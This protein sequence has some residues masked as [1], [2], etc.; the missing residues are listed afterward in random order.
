MWSNVKRFLK[1]CR[2]SEGRKL[3]NQLKDSRKLTQNIKIIFISNKINFLYN[4]Y[5]NSHI[6]KEDIGVSRMAGKK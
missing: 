5:V 2:S 4:T 6:L 3:P 1:A